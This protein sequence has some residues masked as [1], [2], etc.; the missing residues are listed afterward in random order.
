[1]VGDSRVYLLREGVLRQLT[2]DHSLVEEHVRAGE[3]T[4]LEARMSRYRNVITRAIGLA[5]DIQPD[6]DLIELEDGD[7]L[8]LCSDGLTNMLGEDEI[9]EIL[10][11]STE[12]DAA[13]ER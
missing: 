7:T 6:V 13:C 11:S 4:P 9:A 8:L 3:L 2:S 1:N 5:G 12:S 10:A